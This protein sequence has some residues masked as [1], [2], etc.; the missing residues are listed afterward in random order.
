MACKRIS[1]AEWDWKSGETR[2]VKMGSLT[3]PMNYF[4]CG[5]YYFDGVF[6]VVKFPKGLQLYHGSGALANANVEFPIGADFYSSK[7]A[8]PVDRIQLVKELE[9]NP[10]DSVEYSL[11][12][13]LD[14]SAGWF[15]DPKVA[16]TYSRQNKQFSQICGDKCVFSYELIKDATF[17]VLHNNFNIWKLLSDMSVP[18]TAKEQLL[19]MYNL[20]PSAVLKSKLD[21]ENFGEIAILDKKRRSYREV[22]LPFMKWLCGYLPKDYA[23]YAANTSVKNGEPY[24]H[25][26][27]AFCNPTKWLKR[28]MDNPIDWQHNNILEHSSDII[29]LFMQQLS[30]YK[31]INIDF[32]AGDLLEHSIWTLL[33]TEQLMT[34]LSFTEWGVPKKN[35]QMRIAAAAFLHDI[36][37]M[38]PEE[39]LKRSNDYIYYSVPDHPRIGG[40]YIRGKRP[41][42]LL[43]GNMNKIGIFDIQ[44]LLAS[45]G[46]RQEHVEFLANIVDLHWEFGK[47]LQKWKDPEDI[48]T[49][50][51][52]IN[53]VKKSNS[54]FD[55]MYALIIISVADVLAS[56]PFNENNLTVELNHHSKFFPFISNVPKKY[57]GGNIA[58]QTAV[59]RNLFAE[60]IL[61]RSRLVLTT[62]MEMFQLS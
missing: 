38:V 46:F 19:F 31:S 52:F 1:K 41:L 10:T 56:Q 51:A 3:V 36:G 55:F 26:E 25:L 17:I 60:T 27:F 59:K 35:D 39:E 28:N 33:F 8:K 50:D 61:K 15:A 20:S 30:Y 12:K 47:Y 13:F 5:T 11:S 44:S 43:D 16:R 4:S 48:E 40:D 57:R 21:S 58:D 42:P 24:F 23:G 22:D 9:S 18:R 37:K 7:N 6:Q 53:L 29:K 2:T 45:F 32:H 14:I 34:N 62:P 49:V 54:T